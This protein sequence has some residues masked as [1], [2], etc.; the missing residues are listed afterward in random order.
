[1]INSVEYT[2]PHA[3][4]GCEYWTAHD[5]YKAFVENQAAGPAE[6]IE[7][8]NNYSMCSNGRDD[9]TD[10]SSGVRHCTEHAHNSEDLIS[11]IQN[12]TVPTLDRLID[13][14]RPLLQ[15]HRDAAL[16]GALC[17]TLSFP[18]P[19]LFAEPLAR[20]YQKRPQG[21]GMWGLEHRHTIGD[22]LQ[23]NQIDRRYEPLWRS[24]LKDQEDEYLGGNIYDGFNG[25][26]MMPAEAGKPG[27]PDMDVV[28]EALARLIAQKPWRE[29]SYGQDRREDWMDYHLET[30]ISTYPNRPTFVDDLMTQGRL[31]NLPDW[32]MV[33]LWYRIR[34]G[35]QSNR[36]SN[37]E[38]IVLDQE[39]SWRWVFGVQVENQQIED[40]ITRFVKKGWVE[41]T[42][43]LK[44][45][46]RMV[47]LRGNSEAN[48]SKVREY[49]HKQKIGSFYE[50]KPPWK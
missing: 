12:R 46:Q 21:K 3:Q 20:V 36:Y 15:K 30:M 45:S 29:D 33:H 27:Y 39:S 24:M 40:A 4:S 31:H 48:W 8:L 26:L 32:A 16:A 1:M 5:H 6:L 17:L 11:L 18:S 38:K 14:S 22:A 9:M 34:R 35:Y 7:L 10:P 49:F 47:R 37:Q 13:Y 43:S 28:G 50:L 19:K 25:L 2:N 23:C 42:E 41:E 44:G